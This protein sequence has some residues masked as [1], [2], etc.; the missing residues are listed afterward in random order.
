MTESATASRYA[1]GTHP[2]LPPPRRTTGVAGWM[3][4]NLFSSPLNIA[5]TVIGAFVLYS[6]VPRCWNGRS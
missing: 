6:I 2:D 3:Y 4:K 5:L 1:P